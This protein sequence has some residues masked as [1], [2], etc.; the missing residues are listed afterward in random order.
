M[1]AG[2]ENLQL[3]ITQLESIP[4][5]VKNLEATIAELRKSQV[6]KSDNPAFSLR[7]QPT[8]EL[9]S[10]REQRLADMD[11]QI[12]ALRARLPQ[13]QV[14]V[15]ALQDEVTMLNTRKIKAVEGAQEARRRRADGGM[16]DE[17]EERGRWLRVVEMGLRTMLEV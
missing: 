10:E 4:I 14:D 9:L 15:T 5:E 11:R 16:T 2:Y 17:L 6:P 1:S 7:L 8:L 12:E 13:K 3:K